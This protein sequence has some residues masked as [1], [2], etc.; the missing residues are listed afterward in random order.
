MSDL[1]S[2]CFFIAQIIDNNP[3]LR[4]QKV[5]IHK[6]WININKIKVTTKYLKPPY[7]ENKLELINQFLITESNAPESWVE[8]SCDIYDK[9]KSLDEAKNLMN[10]KYMNNFTTEDLFDIN[11][12]L[13]SYNATNLVI[14]SSNQKKSTKRSSDVLNDV[15]ANNNLDLDNNKRLRLTPVNVNKFNNLTPVVPANFNLSISN[16]VTKEYLDNV[17]IKFKDDIISAVEKRNKTDDDL[18]KKFEKSSNDTNAAIRKMEQDVSEIKSFTIKSNSVGRDKKIVTYRNLI[19]NYNLELPFL[20][21]ES[22]VEF[23]KQLKDQQDLKSDIEIYIQD[24][25]IPSKDLKD[26]ITKI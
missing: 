12:S 9:A 6:K 13:S 10:T 18:K 26:E 4:N 14:I 25:V 8:Y 15:F 20:E 21:K 5:I 23:D 16:L 11:K 3:S 2:E 24:N 7:D 1:N 17:L 22:F 19:Q